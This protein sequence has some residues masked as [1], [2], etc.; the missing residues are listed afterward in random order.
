MGTYEIPQLYVITIIDKNG[1]VM[2]DF[3]D[4]GYYEYPARH[5]T[6]TVNGGRSIIEITDEGVKRTFTLDNILKLDAPSMGLDEMSDDE[7]IQ[8]TDGNGNTTVTLGGLI[9]RSG[10]NETVGLEELLRIIVDEANSPSKAALA[11]KKTK[12]KKKRKKK[13]KKLMSSRTNE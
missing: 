6:Y 11:K 10:S 5:G 4:S 3:G 12:R 8:I 1:K 9:K 13:K 7:V 2:N